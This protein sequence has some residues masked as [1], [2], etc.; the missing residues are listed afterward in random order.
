MKQ[1]KAIK[2]LNIFMFLILVVAIPVICSFIPYRTP[3]VYYDQLVN[4]DNTVCVI[5]YVDNPT[6]IPLKGLKITIQVYD[7]TNEYVTT[8]RFEI[9]KTFPAGKKTYFVTDDFRLPSGTDPESATCYA[10]E[11]LYSYN[12]VDWYFIFGIGLLVY[13]LYSLL[14]LKQ[15]YYFEVDGQQVEVYVGMSKTAILVNGQVVQE[16]RRV[17]NG[18][19]TNLVYTLGDKMIRV[20]SNKAFIFPSTKITVDGQKAN[21]TKA[22]QHCF[23]RM[24]DKNATY[25]NAPITSSTTTY[26]PDTNANT[27]VKVCKFCGSSNKATNNKCENCGSDLNNN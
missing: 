24:I 18:N 17:G 25:N 26:N 6:V 23:V 11:I 27:Q 1:V 12:K 4:E 16:Q 8:K 19:F 10:S 9:N 21:I 2:I 7:D 20:A 3:K 13:C 5:G 14:F 22:R 15:K